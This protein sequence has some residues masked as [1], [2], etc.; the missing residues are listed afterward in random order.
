MDPFGLSDLYVN[1]DRAYDGK[2][3]DGNK[4]SMTL[5]IDGKDL[6][7]SLKQWSDALNGTMVNVD[8]VD[9]NFGYGIADVDTRLNILAKFEGIVL[10]T[11]D[12]IPM[13]NN[14]AMSLLSQQVYYVVEEY[15]P[16]L[17]RGGIRYMKYNYDDAEW[18]DYVKSQGG[19][20]TY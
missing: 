17:S 1:P 19:T 5:N 14:G 7:M 3:F 11:Y 18:K 9:Y 4:V 10:G 12:Y 20:L 16:V 8:G 6:T 2:W 15:N 13:M